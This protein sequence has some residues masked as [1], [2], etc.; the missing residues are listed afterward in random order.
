MTGAATGDWS[1]VRCSILCSFVFFVFFERTPIEVEA[2][3]DRS[4]RARGANSRA[5]LVWWWWRWWLVVVCLVSATGRIQRA[6]RGGRA[7]SKIVDLRFVTSPQGESR[8]ISQLF[9]GPPLARAIPSF[10]LAGVF[11]SRGRGRGRG[12]NNDTLLLTL[13]QSG[14]YK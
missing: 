8:S 9:H 11:T 1:G 14:V 5:G 13:S 6:D 12:S 4:R 10:A 7:W 3:V 2:E